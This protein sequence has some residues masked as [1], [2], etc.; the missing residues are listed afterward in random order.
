MGRAGCSQKTCPHEAKPRAASFGNAPTP[1][2]LPGK[3]LADFF[4]FTF[5]LIPTGHHGRKRT[6]RDPALWIMKHPPN[7]RNKPFTLV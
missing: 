5:P 6:S 3:P 2:V 7:G 4:V 1:R